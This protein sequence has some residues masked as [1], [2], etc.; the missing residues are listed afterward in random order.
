[1]KLFDLLPFFFAIMFFSGCSTNSQPA[2][3]DEPVKK[4]VLD[5]TYQE[6]FKALLPEQ[7]QQ[8]YKH[9]VDET[10]NSEVFKEY[11]KIDQQGTGWVWGT[12]TVENFLKFVPISKTAT[13]VQSEI[14]NHIN[15]MN[16]TVNNI[17]TNDNSQDT[18]KTFCEAELGLS[19]GK[20]LPIKYTAQLTDDKK[21]WVE[22]IGLK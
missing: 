19:N 4:V 21:I 17:R 11:E 20:S 18:K 16:I 3:S 1:M 8:N 13:T 7:L 15:T 5:I 22:V 2:C 9:I 12:M 6:F 10:K 14:I